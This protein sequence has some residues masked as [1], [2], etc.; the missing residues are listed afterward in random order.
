MG[1]ASGEK[2][3]VNAAQ[4]AINSPLLEDIS[5]EGAKG[6]L[7]NLTGPSDMTMEEVDEASSY[8]KDEA[9]DAEV[10]WGL[11]YDDSMGDEIQVTVVAT[12]IDGLEEKK[13]GCRVVDLNER[14]QRKSIQ[15]YANVV[16]L[17]DVTIEDIEEE[18]TVKKDG[19]SLDT[20]TFQRMGSN[21]STYLEEKFEKK[22]K[23][24]FFDKFRIKD[25]LDYP[26]F[27]RAKAD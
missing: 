4:Q 21:P 1:R 14:V 27:L 19:I 9:K 23:K 8:I 26:T 13:A 5:I 20:P 16:N 2:R 12:G 17:R 18:W 7:M 25:G 15:D 11:V 22:K 3:A 24:S 6:L 10:F